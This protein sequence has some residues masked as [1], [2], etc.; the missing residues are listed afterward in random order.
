MSSTHV[1]MG[2]DAMKRPPV[3]PVV[4]VGVFDGVHI[5]HQQLI[6]STRI[7]ARRLRGTSVVITFDPDPQVVL[8]PS[9][10]PFALMPLDERLRCLRNL[11][12][13]WIW[14]I[15]FTK[16]FAQTTAEQFVRHILGQ[17]LRAVA[18]VV[19]E[20]FAFGRQRRG[21]TEVLQT[22][23][24]LH[25]IQIVA[26]PPVRREGAPVSSS[27]IRRLIAQ[28]KLTYA[29]RLLSRPPTLYGTIVRGVG[30]GRRLGF[31]TANIQ[32]VHQVLPPTGVY[33]VWLRFEGS[34]RNWRGVMNLGVRPTFGPGPFVCEVHLLNFSGT[35]Q[36]RRVSVSLLTHLRNERHFDNSTKLVR[37]IQ[38]DLLHAQRVFAK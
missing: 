31:P 3:R 14:V 12:V 10:A 6:G 21:N 24:P 32:L 23:G 33:A 22:L 34:L 13:G 11:G 18:L 35:L 36:H 19:G 20:G 5:A 9:R 38:R 29:K 8:E 2:V 25:G 7:L 16:H 26:V 27:R 28:G 15:P 1:V 37:Q 30:R 17:R 4:T